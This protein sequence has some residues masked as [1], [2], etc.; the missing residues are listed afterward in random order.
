MRVTDIAAWAG[1]VSG[2]TALCWD[3]YK[4]KTAGP[5]LVATVTPG[6]AKVPDR[7]KNARY[8]V[9]SVQNRGTSPTTLTN[10]ALAVYESWLSRMQLKRTKAFVAY[11]PSTA[12]PL[13]YK[14][15]VGAQWTGVV[16]QDAELELLI[17]SG[18]LWC[19]FYDAWSKRPL[20]ARVHKPNKKPA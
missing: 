4:W 15:D 12:Q 1:A 3:F 10:M 19:E 8:L 7:D 5:K 14:L 13:P 16:K 18:N 9:A 17:N 6:V 11:Q 20:F 2:F